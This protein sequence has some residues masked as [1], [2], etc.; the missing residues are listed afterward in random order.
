M[1]ILTEDAKG[2]ATPRAEAALHVSGL[3]V[4]GRAGFAL[5]P[6]TC[7]V[8]TGET[9]LVL[10]SASSGKSLFLLALAGLVPATSGSITLGGEALVPGREHAHRRHVGLAFQRDA[11]VADESALLNVARAARGRA[12]DAPDDRAREALVSVGIAP[13]HHDALPRMLS[14][15]M[16]RRVGLARALVSRPPLLLL[17]DPTAGLDPET[18]RDVAGYVREVSQHAATLIVTHEVDLFLPHTRDVLLLSRGRVVAQ[19]PWAKV[20][21][22][23]LAPFRP[24]ERG[25]LA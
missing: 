25:G 14:G 1:P 3:V 18:A 16:R 10:G 8:S 24:R 4:D 19:G 5:G 6:V 21:D 9:W 22:D 20:L 12:M 7:A 11:L 13:A 2:Q 23:A 15:G 17:D